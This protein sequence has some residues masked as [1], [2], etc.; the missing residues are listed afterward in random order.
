MASDTLRVGFIGCGFVTRSRHLP[1]LAR[2]REVAA[3]ALADLDPA[4]L[5]RT[6]DEWKISR[7][8]RD[9]LALI[10]DPEVEAV[11]I[12]TPAAGHVPLALAALDAGRHVFV[13]KPLA[14][15]LAE[16]DRL[17]A[18]AAT[19]ANRVLVG[20]NLR[21]HRLALRA[22]ELLAGAAIGR[23]RAVRSTFSDPLSS[24]P[25]L[26]EW[27]RRRAQGGG[28]L[29]DKGIHHFDLWRYLLGDEVEVIAA[30]AASAAS[31]DEVAVVTARARSGAEL[32]ALVMDTSAVANEMT[33]Y[34]DT[35]SLHLDF[36]RSDGLELRS[37]AELPGA[38]IARLRRL[39]G[40]LAGL[41]GNA[42]E[43]LRGG[44]FDTAYDRQWRH[45]AEVVRHDLPPGCSLRDGREALAIALAALACAGDP[46][47][48][49]NAD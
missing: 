23:V 29:L 49:S 35:G 19:S 28:S 45:F 38:P 48:G 37:A 27:R 44:A 5:D 15:S 14:L 47:G 34:G 30:T 2:V 39:G 18:R 33:L 13:E 26:P 41:A 12:C 24:R 40:S 43:L 9:P 20:F 46:R 32:T 8:H 4:A 36:Y 3:V 42:G 21:W 16:A 22:R 10:E 11:A 31:D 17:A 6:G 25:G 7:R 1:A